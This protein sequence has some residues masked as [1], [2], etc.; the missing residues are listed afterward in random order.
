MLSNKQR[1]ILGWV[2]LSPFIVFVVLSAP[3]IVMALI[4]VAIVLLAVGL[5]FS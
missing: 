1:K 3:E 2:L 4:C 5:I